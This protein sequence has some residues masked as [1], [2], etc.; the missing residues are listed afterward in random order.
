MDKNILIIENQVLQFEIISLLLLKGGIQPFPSD[1]S[2]EYVNFI[3]HIRIWVNDEYLS[4]H[5]DLAFSY[6]TSYIENNRINLVLMDY[7]LGGAHHCKTGIDLAE[8]LNNFRLENNQELLP[9]YFLS[10]TELN[11]RK[12][13][14][15]FNN[16]KGKFDKTE[17]IH[18]GYFGEE[19]LETTYFNKN[20]LSLI[21]NFLVSKNSTV[22]SKLKAFISNNSFYKT[23]FNEKKIK[24]IREL[25][26]LCSIL[27]KS[28]DPDRYSSYIDQLIKDE[29]YI[30][31]SGYNKSIA[32]IINIISN[33][34]LNL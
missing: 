19:I 16:Y 9:V 15:R 2:D 23:T 20:V 4:H 21:N 5:R 22:V 31:K 8:E 26:S 1:S 25:E 6:L 24:S 3:D 18:K 14:E 13:E 29:V 30:G 28:D 33:P 10:K 32:N 34:K 11:D 12:R 7:K 17:W 27:E